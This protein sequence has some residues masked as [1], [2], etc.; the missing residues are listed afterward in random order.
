MI[1]ESGHT[2]LTRLY[3]DRLHS[4]QATALLGIRLPAVSR[5]TG[6]STLRQ[7]S[8]DRRDL[9]PIVTSGVSRPDTSMSKVLSKVRLLP[10]VGQARLEL[11]LG[12]AL[13]RA[14]RPQPG[15]RTHMTTAAL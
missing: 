8:L 15:D 11:S 1:D 9:R 13:L 5:N 7:L 14:D 6:R 12:Q 10:A 3:R 2:R 4:C